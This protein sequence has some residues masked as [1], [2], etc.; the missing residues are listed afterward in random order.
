MNLLFSYKWHSTPR[1]VKK[2]PV[3]FFHHHSPERSNQT[4]NHSLALLSRQKHILPPYSTDLRNPPSTM[5]SLFIVALAS[6][7]GMTASTAVQPRQ[8]SKAE[9]QQWFEYVHGTLQFPKYRE[10]AFLIYPDTACY[11][12]GVNPNLFTLQHFTDVANEDLLNMKS[13]SS[14]SQANNNTYSHYK[15]CV[16]DAYYGF[17]AGM[18]ELQGQYGGD[19]D[20]VIAEA[21]TNQMAA[22][23]CPVS[24]STTNQN[25]P[26]AT[27]V[28]SP[29]ATGTGAAATGSG[30]SQTGGG[31]EDDVTPTGTAA[32][33]KEPAPT[34]SAGLRAV[35]PMGLEAFAL[36]AAVAVATYLL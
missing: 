26:T 10:V 4:C 21:L 5:H 35:S 32:T 19:L 6:L 33:P 9:C 13:W 14:Q 7:A 12:S 30:A 34:G 29:T 20:Q 8:S 24:T 22:Q 1:P 28:T 25:G 17:E 23:G 3:C 15:D 2:F 11:L 31:P 36:A 16:V 27:S 18:K